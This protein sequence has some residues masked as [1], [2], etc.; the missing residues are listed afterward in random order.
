MDE[1][2]DRLINLFG[3]LVQGVEDRIQAATMAGMALGGEAAAAI[4]VIGHGA[5]LSI[6]QLARVLRLSHPGTVRLVDRLANAGFAQ[7]NVAPHDRR[8][9]VLTLTNHG[10]TERQVLLERRHKALAAILQATTPADRVVLERVAETLLPTLSVDA[11]SALTVCRFCNEQKCTGCPMELFGSIP[12]A[13][14]L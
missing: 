12:T 8:V 2:S 6:N 7:R 9:V 5:S 4:I 14:V 3:A 10:R 1:P 11:T 13:P